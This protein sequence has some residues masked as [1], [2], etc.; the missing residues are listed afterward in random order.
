MLTKDLIRYTKRNKQIFPQFIDTNSQILL[1]LAVKLIECFEKGIRTS[2][3]KILQEISSPIIYSHRDLTLTRGFLKLL[4]DRSSF[5]TEL[6]ESYPEFRKKIFLYSHS[7]R[8]KPVQLQDFQQN[9]KKKFFLDFEKLSNNFYKDLPENFV[10]KEF[11]SISGEKLLELYNVSLVQSLLLYSDQLEIQLKDSDAGKYRSLFRV[12]KFHQLLGTPIQNKGQ[13]EPFKL[14]V[15]GPMSILENSKKYGIKLAS[16]FP[17]VCEMKTWSLWAEIRL[18]HPSRPLV[19]S[20]NSSTG[21]RNPYKRTHFIP[22]ELE[23]FRKEFNQN[24]T[25]WRLTPFSKWVHLNKQNFILPDFTIINNLGEEYHIEL[26]HRWYASSLLDRLAIVEEN[27]V[28]NIFIGVDRSLTKK[29]SVKK[30]IAESS[31]FETYGF[32]FREIP[33]PSQVIKLLKK[34]SV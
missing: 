25:G 30:R 24:D 33:V 14:I 20:I 19:L 18:D 32:S 10:L 23:L 26:F 17:H 16:F 7:L 4:M 2:T 34:L 12:L 29:S 1:E 6:I 22:E 31:W 3:F 28:K 27:Q 13:S 15:D 21:L 11:K 8:Q 5:D 9:L